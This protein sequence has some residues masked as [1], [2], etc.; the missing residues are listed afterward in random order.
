MTE[1]KRLLASLCIA[2]P[3]AL[4]L[5]SG[6]KR[7]ATE[8]QN[9]A[10][11]AQKEA[12]DKIAMAQ[13]EADKKAAEAQ[14]RALDETAASRDETNRMQARAQS[15]ANETIRQAN[16]EIAKKRDELRTWARQKT[17][18]IDA[19]VDTAKTH[20]QT[21]SANVKGAFDKAL[22]DV[23]AKR[24][25]LESHIASIDQQSA[26]ELDQMK[27]RLQKEIDAL[28]ASVSHLRGTL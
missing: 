24:N 1:I 17:D 28:K 15:G 22:V 9:R 11:Q 8:E 21:A 19:D 20:A 2:A 23:E 27:A 18:S 13:R 14:Q 7:S 25:A 16:E 6:C 3:V 26:T 10:L 5:T 4:A 12:D